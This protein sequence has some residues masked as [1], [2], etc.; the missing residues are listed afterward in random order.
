MINN[1]IFEINGSVKWYNENKGY[2]FIVNLDNAFPDI[3]IHSSVLN[4][5]GLVTLQEGDQ[6]YC[7][8]EPSRK[9]DGSSNGY[10]VRK[11]ISIG[12]NERAPQSKYSVIEEN[13]SEVKRIYGKIKW[14]NPKK[15]FGFVY[16]DDNGPEI[17]FHDSIL[18][19]HQQKF[20]PW[21]EVETFYVEKGGKR[22]ATDIITL[23]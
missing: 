9:S 14:F 12:F 3:F 23:E 8:V 19:P 1:D 6:L 18:S 2:G 16:P 11:I 20:S 21:T 5:A 4:S 10:Q 7:L 17:F 13:N 15:G 22:T